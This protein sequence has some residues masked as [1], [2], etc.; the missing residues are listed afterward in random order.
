MIL[1]V[2]VVLLIFLIAGGGIGIYC[3][4]LSHKRVENLSGWYVVRAAKLRALEKSEIPAANSINAVMGYL[5]YSED[6]AYCIPAFSSAKIEAI[7]FKLGTRIPIFVLTKKR[8][9]IFILCR[10]NP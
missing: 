8:N 7:G 1:N 3:A 6:N 5:G 9:T 4:T 2:F 10:G